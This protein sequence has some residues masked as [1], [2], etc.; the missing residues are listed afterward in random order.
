MKKYVLF[1]GIDISK[2]WFDASLTIDGV[3]ELMIHKQFSNTLKGYKSFIH[4]IRKQQNT[5]G[6]QGAYLICLEHTGIYTLPLCIFLQDQNID[7]VLESALRIKRSLGIRRGKDDKADSK[8]IALYT[9]LNAKQ[10]KISKLPAKELMKL[11]SLLVHRDRL[12]K[13][14]VAL[15]N[16]TGE[17][18]EYMPQDFFCAS[19]IEDN[20]ELIQILNTKIR[21]VEKE[22][23]TIIQNNEQLS[24]LY[25]LVCSVKGIGNIIAIT[26]LVY[27]NCFKAFDNPKKFA[28]YIGIAPF[29]KQS[30]SSL[31]INAKVS[32]LAYI[33]I[34]A[35]LGNGVN[36]AIQHDKELRAYYLRKLDEG[37][38]KFKVLN[39]LK[40][41]LISRVFATVKR[42]TPYVELFRYT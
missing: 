40:N 5:L 15:K 23:K 22:M 11:K 14:R 38:N 30:G 8:D 29:A 32:K 17:Y 26:L 12:V 18:K 27:T 2:K 33:K 37:K 7:Y 36:S 24:N 6:I 31:Y 28:C 19:I 3:K 25:N 9:F 10:L 35:L 42:G 13:Q 41:K 4:W 34:K 20:Q 21:M 1:I 16:A 39:A